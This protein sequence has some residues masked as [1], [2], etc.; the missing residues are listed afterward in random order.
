MLLIRC[1]SASA[2]TALKGKQII[3]EK[4]ENPAQKMQNGKSIQRFSKYLSFF[5]RE[6]C[7]VFMHNNIRQEETEV[8]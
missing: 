6:A 5:M 2:S 1:I 7:H 3:L 8:M 4:R